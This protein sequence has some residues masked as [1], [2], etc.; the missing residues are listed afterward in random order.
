MKLKWLICCLFWPA[1]GFLLL[2]QSPGWRVSGIVQDEQGELL[3]GAT[4][5][6]N[7]SVQGIT[8]AA[9][10]FDLR[11][12]DKPRQI[13]V[14]CIGYFPQRI[15]L[16]TLPFAG[17]KTGLTIVLH[18]NAVALPEIAITEKPV[19]QIFEEDFQTDL[20]DFVFA[21]KDLMLLVREGKKY[22]LR[23]TDDN[24]RS[25]AALRLPEPI[26]QLHQS[27]TGDFHAVG[28]RWS[29]EFTLDGRQ[30]DTFP[31]YPSETFHRLVEP[32]VLEQNGYYF[33]RKTGPF[34]QSVRYIY[35]DPA[36]QQHLLAVIRDQVAE[37]QLLRRY[38]EI[39]YAYMLTIPD[40]DRD[41]ILSGQSPLADP[42]QAL[43][44]E[45][46]TKMAETNALL[47]AIGFFNQ[48]ALD[49]VYAPLIKLGPDLFLL[50][51]V[52]DQ[53]LQFNTDTWRDRTIPLNYHRTPGW[54]KEVLV[55]AALQRVYGC[56]TTKAGYRILK[57]IDLQTGTSRKSYRLTVIPYLADHFKLRNGILYC[58]GQP[59]MN[60]P[61]RKL[62]KVNLFKFAE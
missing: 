35:Y 57:E 6:L 45:N 49:S 8:D 38:R 44:P 14:R 3:P 11:I 43:K 56:F 16:D 32:C 55:D 21:G 31:R 59:D 47:T 23:L 58:I 19:E 46:L 40:V 4:V 12:T 5:Q 37:D 13:T 51:H 17:Q 62:Y 39:L 50:D 28:E 10:L 52:N 36:H 27:C 41:D 33:F 29:W 54:G 24:G 22:F 48:L 15:L 18:S 2:A 20:L 53:I 9:G 25:I 42:M 30:I 26:E 34:R 7:D 1:G 61:N 60:V